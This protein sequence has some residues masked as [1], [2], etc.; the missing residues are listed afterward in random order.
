MGSHSF[1]DLIRH[2]GH[3]IKCVSYGDPPHNASVECMTCGEVI[4]DFDKDEPIDQYVTEEELE[5]AEREA[6]VSRLSRVPATRR[7]RRR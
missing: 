3:E 7:D 4:I 1:E 5:G 6:K 2:V